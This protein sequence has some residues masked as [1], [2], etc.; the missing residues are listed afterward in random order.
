[1]TVR[2]SLTLRRDPQSVRAARGALEQL[3]GHFP[4]A[5]LYDAT[6]C[7]SELVS[8]AIRHPGGGGELELTVAVDDELLRVEVADP[9]QGF[10]P[11]PPTKGD[12][13]GGWGLFIVDRLADGWG[14]EPGEQTVVWF[15]MER[16]RTAEATGERR[17][18]DRL[19]R[20]AALRLKGR[21]AS[22]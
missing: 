16:E 13:R 20:A 17:S 7:L 1:V 4:K 19:L 11:G 8:N 9:G 2:N 21:L 3:D 22:P 18:D 15:E 10:E 6:V 14:V 12:E 5:R